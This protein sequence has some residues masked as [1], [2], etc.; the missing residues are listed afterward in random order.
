MK[1]FFSLLLLAFLFT[2]C[3]TDPPQDS[4]LESF[5]LNK[6]KIEKIDKVDFGNLENQT[7]AGDEVICNQTGVGH[8]I[9][10]ENGQMDLWLERGGHSRWDVHEDISTQDMWDFCFGEDRSI[11][12]DLSELIKYDKLLALNNWLEHS[13][14]K[15]KDGGLQ[16]LKLPA[17]VDV[18]CSSYSTQQ[19]VWLGA[20]GKYYMTIPDGPNSWW[21]TQVYNWETSCDNIDVPQL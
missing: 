5:D 14:F 3:S 2:S 4:L 21:T 8:I 7:R 6:A 13:T 9:V 16:N 10:R 18:M 12:Y 17:P 1:Q 11:Q 19:A 15:D 20:D